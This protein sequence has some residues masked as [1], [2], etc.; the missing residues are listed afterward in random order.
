MRFSDSECQ[1]AVVC[2]ILLRGGE[3]P[4]LKPIRVLGAFCAGLKSI[5][6]LLKQGAPTER[7]TSASCEAR[8]GHCAIFGACKQR[9]ARSGCE[10]VLGSGRIWPSLIKVT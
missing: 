3:I 4:G 2:V 1:L 6:S 5:S 7:R 9:L 8:G 10:S